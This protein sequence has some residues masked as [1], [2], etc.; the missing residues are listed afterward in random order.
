ML[1]C[2]DGTYSLRAILF[3]FHFFVALSI[4]ID[5]LS[6]SEIAIGGKL[7]RLTAMLCVSNKSWFS[8]SVK[9]T[10]DIEP[11]ARSLLK[12][13][14]RVVAYLLKSASHTVR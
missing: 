3:F 7:M 10:K 11:V 1:R 8:G 9:L 2:D 4:D 14:I 6:S 12:H 5:T 13:P